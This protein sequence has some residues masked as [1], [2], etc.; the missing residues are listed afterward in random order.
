[1]FQKNNIMSGSTIRTQL[2][3]GVVE[4]LI[5]KPENVNTPNYR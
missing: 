5:S 4:P 2:A 3:I 1:M